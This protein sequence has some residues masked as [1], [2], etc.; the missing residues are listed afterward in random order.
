MPIPCRQRALHCVVH[1][2]LTQT[3]TVLWGAPWA[4]T[5]ERR[6]SRDDVCGRQQAWEVAAISRGG[7]EHAKEG[8]G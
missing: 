1:A 7:G 3:F 6:E 4:W 8:Q 5:S 2:L